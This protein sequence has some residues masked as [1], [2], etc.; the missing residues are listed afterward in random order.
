MQRIPIDQMKPGMITARPVI[1]SEG[2]TLLA[3]NT[4]MTD[5]YISRLARLGVGSIYI[6]DGLDDIEILDVVEDDV[7]AVVTANL[8]KTLKSFSTNQS[9][10]IAPFKK[11]VEML[12]ESILRNRNHLLQLE[13]IHVFS[14]YILNHSINVAIY[15]MITGITLGYTEAKLADLGLGALLHD[16]GMIV[17]DPKIISSTAALTE[18]ERKQITLHPKMGFNILHN[19]NHVS[20]LVA[21]IAF[22]HHE[23]IDGS[24]YPRQL[25]GE[26]MLDYARIV[27]VVDT[28][29]AM[30]SDRPYRP[31]C[32]TTDALAEIKSLSG[33]HFDREVVEAFS[34]NIASYPIGSLL[35]LNTGHIA[36]VR[37]VTKF[38]K[39]R[40]V[41]TVIADE[42]GTFIKPKY[43]IDLNRSSEVGIV[44]RIN[45]E[46]T[47]AIKNRMLAENKTAHTG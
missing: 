36:M 15:A 40:P 39:D 3:P 18:L 22:Q 33:K 30:V 41:I 31:G 28:F 2:K 16:I 7:K 29:D 19:Q 9:L 38:N 35:S 44:R 46:E 45:N 13:E 10:D 43:E 23:R 14:D 47:E 25:T 42:T 5:A 27:A 17:I 21:H 20:S 37:S 26:Q 34:S 8:Q 1:G 32:T 6:K 4:E 24:G 11:G 12:L